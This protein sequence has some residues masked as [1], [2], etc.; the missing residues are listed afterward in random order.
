MRIAMNRQACTSL[1]TA[2]IDAPTRQAIS[3]LIRDTYN[4][5]TPYHG[6][7]DFWTWKT[8][9]GTFP[10]R[11]AKWLKGHNQKASNDFLGKVGSIAGSSVA[12]VSRYTFDFDDR[13]D[14]Y[15]GDFGDRGS[16]YWGDRS[17]A[18][19][20]IRDN[21]AFALRFFDEHGNGIARSWVSPWD[22]GTFILWNG[23]DGNCGNTLG[24]LAQAR[25]LAHLLGGTYRKVGLA[26]NGDTCGTLYI[27]S[28]VA[29]VIG[30]PEAVDECDDHIDFG[31]EE[32][33]CEHCCVC[34]DRVHEDYAHYTD[35]DVYC[36]S[37]F[38][39]RFGYCDECQ[40]TTRHEDLTYIN[41]RDYC[42][43]CRDRL[44]SQC[45]ACDEWVRIEDCQCIDDSIYC[46]DC[47]CDRY[48]TCCGCAEYVARDDAQDVDGDLYCPD[49]AA[50]LTAQEAD[51]CAS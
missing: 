15:A 35:Y 18:R 44:F 28:G 30:D 49:C 1:P 26:N 19:D 8:S 38:D 40:E 9:R 23:Y 31:W 34:G 6:D 37:C 7:D 25:I 50:R 2:D 14:W 43:Y 29:Y 33:A 47:A 51:A 39:D 21:G 27:N 36:E 20:M 13:I 45:E 17:E 24:T 10:K 41:G 4:L 46:D 3:R 16:C 48:A 42:D 5:Y 12:D 32:P 11:L 22:D